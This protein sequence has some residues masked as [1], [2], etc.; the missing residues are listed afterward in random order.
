MRETVS[1]FSAAVQ[2]LTPQHEEVR[3][4]LN[5]QELKDQEME[6]QGLS[7]EL[8]RKTEIRLREERV[9]EVL[10]HLCPL[11]L[12]R[13][14]SASTSA[15]L[16]SCASVSNSSCHPH[17]RTHLS[18]Q[19]RNHIGTYTN[20]CAHPPTHLQKAREI[21]HEV[22]RVHIEALHGPPHRPPRPQHRCTQHRSTRLR[23][24]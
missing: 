21:L 8:R 15:Q 17:I 1:F 2:Q 16:P 10:P 6:R 12:S 4:Y 24:A 14:R 18:R 20:I 22:I 13:P 3:R 9:R 19:F 5:D 23:P 11:P 7:L